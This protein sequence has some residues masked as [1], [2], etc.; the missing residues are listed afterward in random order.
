MSRITEFEFDVPSCL[1]TA[2]RYGQDP[3]RWTC[4]HVLQCQPLSACLFPLY[5]EDS[6]WGFSAENDLSK[7][8]EEC[9]HSHTWQE[10]F[11]SQENGCCDVI[12]LRS[13]FFWEWL[14]EAHPRLN[15][16]LNSIREQFKSNS[17][18]FAASMGN[19]LI[20][21]H[22]N[23]HEFLQSLL[24][25]N[26]YRDMMTIYIP[27]IFLKWLGPALT[28]PRTP[29]LNTHKPKPKVIDRWRFF[30]M[31]E[32]H[33]NCIKLWLNPIKYTSYWWYS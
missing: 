16:W 33:G 13:T 8:R 22:G 23:W 31:A 12:G 9:Y 32:I 14:D 25:L 5:Y 27:C 2:H 29:D 26:R 3:P 24:M 4:W 6:Y 21:T 10:V 19:E 7:Q 28:K 20:C 30:V 11:F 18:N 15:L 1:H 17:N